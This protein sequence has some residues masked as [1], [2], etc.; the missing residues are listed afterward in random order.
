MKKLSK[1][2]EKD[3]MRGIQRITVSF[4]DDDS[5]YAVLYRVIQALVKANFASE[6]EIREE[7]EML[8]KTYN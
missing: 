8:L 2:L 5:H 4:A 7:W 1:P 6:E 3:P